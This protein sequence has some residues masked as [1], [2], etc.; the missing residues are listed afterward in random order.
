MQDLC[1]RICA[2]RSF[3]TTCARSLSQDLHQDPF[4]EH[5][6]KISVSESLPQYPFGAL[7]S[8]FCR[9]LVQ[10]FCFRTSASGSFWGAQRLCR[11][12]VLG[13]VDRDPFAALVS[14]DPAGPLVGDFCFAISAPGSFWEHL[15]KISLSLWIGRILRKD[16]C[17]RICVL[18]IR[19]LFAHLNQDPVQ[20]HNARF[21]SQDLC[22]R[23]LETNQEQLAQDL[24]HRTSAPGL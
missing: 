11:I 24:C 21:L 19:I 1:L 2:S 15:C 10:D 3:R 13:S 5:L 4:G 23:V 6:C 22:I 17:L 18:R 7:V 14:W 20:D 8:G 9:P 12:S 16:L